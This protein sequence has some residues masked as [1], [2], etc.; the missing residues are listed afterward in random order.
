MDNAVH[1]QAQTVLITGATGAIGSALAMAYAQPG[2]QL[3]LHGRR[4]GVLANLAERCREKGAHVETSGVDL[5]DDKALAEWLV[6]ISTDSLPDIAIF[7]AGQ[8]AH[9]IST[10]YLEPQ[11]SVTALIDI[12]LKVPMAMAQHLVPAMRARGSGQLAFISS[13]AG[14]H[15]LPSTPAYSATKAGIKAY[16]EA[17]RGLLAP[18]GIGV[19]V[20]LPGYVT[21]PMCD[22]MP[23]PKPFEMPAHKAAALIQ[24]GI[25]GNKARISFPFPL[26]FGT[27]WLAVLPAA[28]SQRII[29]LLGFGR[30]KR[31][32]K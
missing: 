14:W 26:N 10:G 2:A 32:A 22:A 6:Q 8:N 12:N 16:G 31:E 7:N 23:G 20:I 18:V 11:D 15:G 24:R 28:I 4:H 13:L 3:I 29:R 9:P 1:S 19:S 25:A 21:S 17:L 30:I 27:W 5:T